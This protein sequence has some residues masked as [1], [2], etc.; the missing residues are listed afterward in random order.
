MK[1]KSAGTKRWPLAA[2]AMAVLAL[3]QV[4]CTEKPQTLNATQK[5]I[6]TPSWKGADNPFVASGWKEGDQASWEE[7]IK[8]RA[9]G[10]NEYLRTN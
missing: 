5:K 6:D 1:T 4:A 3:T 9:M 2:V 8:K 7:Q 10:Q